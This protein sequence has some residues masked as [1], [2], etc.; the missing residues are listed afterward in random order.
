MYVTERNMYI[1][2]LWKVS[3]REK[4]YT[5]LLIHKGKMNYIVNLTIEYFSFIFLTQNCCVEK[6]MYINIKIYNLI[7][8][9]TL[10]GARF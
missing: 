4:Y 6:Y 2:M 3:R 1:D 8:L 9:S 5:K 10:A 7:K